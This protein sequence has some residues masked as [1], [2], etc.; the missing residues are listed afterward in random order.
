MDPC[1]TDDV[2]ATSTIYPAP[3]PPASAVNQDTRVLLGATQRT[4]VA[5]LS[6]GG[7]A[8]AGQLTYLASPP[9]TQ[10]QPQL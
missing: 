1:P 3:H 8:P 4:Q 7:D 6:A 10:N 2:D 9:P 5:G